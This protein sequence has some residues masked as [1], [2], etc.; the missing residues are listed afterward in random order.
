MEEATEL[1]DL[2]NEALR[3]R[4]VCAEAYQLAGVINAPTKVLDNLSAAANGEPLPHES[5]L[6]FALPETTSLDAEFAAC[7][8]MLSDARIELDTLRIA[9]GVDYEPHQSVFERMLDEI[10]RLRNEA[11]EH[12]MC[13]ECKDG[14]I[15][16]SDCSVHNGPAMPKGSCDCGKIDSERKF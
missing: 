7:N 9:L 4:A 1:V 10:R 12:C 15:H 8:D 11:P 14:H 2:V 13:E 16:A 5:F 6:P 3:L